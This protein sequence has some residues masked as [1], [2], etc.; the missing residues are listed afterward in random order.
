M[1][2]DSLATVCETVGFILLTIAWIFLLHRGRRVNREIGPGAVVTLLAVSWANYLVNT[3]EWLGIDLSTDLDTIEDSLDLLSPL[4]WWFLLYSIL[5]SAAR[6][7]LKESEE[8][9]TTLLDSLDD[10]A[11]SADMRGEFL[12][13]SA[14][15]ETVYGRSRD[16][17]LNDAKFWS[18]AVHPDDRKVVEAASNQLQAV[19]TVSVD[20]RILRPDGSIRWLNDR[21]FVITA[22]DGMQRLGGLARDIT[23]RKDTEFALRQSEANLAQ[24][25]RRAGL[26]SWTLN[27][28]SGDAWWSDEMY[29]LHCIQPRKT[30]PTVPEQMELLVHPDDCA[31]FLHFADH[32]LLRQEPKAIEF[33]S[34]PINGRVRHLSAKLA[35]QYDHA[36]EF[37][38]LAGTL[39]DITDRVES[40]QAVRES[41]TR[42]RSIFDQAAVGVAHIASNS[43]EILRVNRRYGEVLGNLPSDI[44]GKTWM[45]LTHPDDLDRDLGLMAKLLAGETR[46]FA[47]EKR[48]QRSDNSF[49]WI[50]LT[51]SPMWEPGS[52]PTTHIAIVED[53]SE[54]KAAEADRERL[55]DIIQN[56]LNEIYVFRAEDYG[57]EYV[58]LGALQNLGYSAEQMNNMTPVDIKPEYSAQEFDRLVKPLMLGEENSIT[59]TTTHE[60][61]DGTLYPV[62]VHLQFIG[63]DEEPVF[64]AV[65]LDLTEKVS[66]EERFR[67]IVEATQEWIWEIDQHGLHTY[68]NPAVRTILGYEIDDVVGGNALSLLIDEDRRVVAERLPGLIERK[69]GWTGWVLRWRHASGAVRYLESNATPIFDMYGG[70]VGYRGSDRDITDRV[71]ADELLRISE[72]R[73]RLM[74]EHATEAVVVLDFDTARFYDFNQR[75]CEFFQATPE[76]LRQLGPI[77]LSPPKQPN[78]E[79]SSE[80]AMFWIQA[81][82]NGEEP[83][84][85]WIHQ[86]TN[87]RQVATE[88]R[89]LRLPHR[90][91]K[92]VR[93]TISDITE[94]RRAADELKKNREELQLLNETLEQRVAER[95]NELQDANEDLEAYAHSVAHDLRAPLRAMYGFARALRED[96]GD[97]LDEHGREYTE[98]IDDAA[99]QMDQLIKDLLEYSKVG[100]TDMSIDIIDVGEV[101]GSSIEHLAAEIDEANADFSINRPLG[102]VTGHRGTLLQAVSNLI[103]NAIKFVAAG[104]Q[105][106]V[107]IWTEKQRNGFLIINL[108]DN[109]IGIEKEYQN[110]IFRVFERLHGV[111]SFPGTGI[112]L[113]IVRRAVES[114]NGRFGLESEVGKGSRFWIELP[115]AEVSDGS[116]AGKD[117]SSC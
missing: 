22:P 82:L 19:G 40:E 3:I 31:R 38:G 32:T 59:F 6:N 92:L 26:G 70:V 45:E 62:E 63:Y 69:E 47:M 27:T 117:D 10:V 48:L 87:G 30:P 17:L 28:E 99:T 18:D 102:V 106:Q 79:V 68:S 44:V 115:C 74:T 14:A 49:V 61:T 39:L 56:S 75:A 80:A 109:G 108:K 86:D 76:E 114:M 104:V 113:A 33:R 21:K 4:A 93:G 37:L 97:K 50:N 29:R 16:E 1:T 55:L 89:L 67:N 90:R 88:V 112:G 15:C 23:D 36:G 111:E 7:K 12:F 110:R 96:Y 60:R 64:L 73:Y 46:K 43:G 51:V 72:E 24:A 95:T 41:E 83:V 34:K 65:I 2:L 98:F 105:P 9:F 84:F 91:R 78:G 81:A 57:F 101:I 35:P 107:H 58:N 11:W 5:Q 13:L 116:G 53:I 8:R 42:F 77:D 25:E 94:R 20:Y 54:R 52:V 66:A 85:E 71:E 100:R 103:S